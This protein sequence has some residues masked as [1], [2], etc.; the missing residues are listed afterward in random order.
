[1]AYEIRH[2]I[3]CLQHDHFGVQRIQNYINKL[4]VN[5]EY[6]DFFIQ[7]YEKWRTYNRMKCLPHFEKM[8]LSQFKVYIVA[9]KQLNVL[10]AITVT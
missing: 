6:I 5:R 2:Y 7:I 4:L 10:C 8:A 3:H 9:E 1:M